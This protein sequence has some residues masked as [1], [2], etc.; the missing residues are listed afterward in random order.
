MIFRS[1]S[2]WQNK[3][4]SI[5]FFFEFSCIPTFEKSLKKKNRVEIFVFYQ[6]KK[7]LKIMIWRW[8]KF[9]ENMITFDFDQKNLCVIAI[10]LN[11]FLYQ[12]FTIK[13]GQSYGHRHGEGYN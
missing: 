2:N 12:L 11:S 7:C 1:C 13:Y 5:F 3:K 10:F 8:R 4:I 6:F 9:G